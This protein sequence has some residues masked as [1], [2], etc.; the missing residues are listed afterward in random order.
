[1][2][3]GVA[4]REVSDVGPAARTAISLKEV[5]SQE[6]GN[7]YKTT[8]PKLSPKTLAISI[9]KFDMGEPHA[10]DYLKEIINVSIKS[11]LN[12]LYYG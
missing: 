12:Q 9:P 8:D 1:M 7:P 11:N 2:R 6:R 4:R 3:L 5:Q 10:P